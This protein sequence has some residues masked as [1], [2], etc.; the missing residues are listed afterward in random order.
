MGSPHSFHNP[1]SFEVYDTESTVPFCVAGIASAPVNPRQ[2][3]LTRA[4]GSLLPPLPQVTISQD[5][6]IHYLAP[7]PF[8]PLVAEL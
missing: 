3:L 8:L 2:S 5:G 6:A 1:S 4:R 7:W